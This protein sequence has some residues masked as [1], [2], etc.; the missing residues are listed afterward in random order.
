MKRLPAATQL[1][2]LGCRE[3]LTQQ[4]VNPGRYWLLSCSGSLPRLLRFES[5]L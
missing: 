1:C 4:W 5:Q 2:R 3:G